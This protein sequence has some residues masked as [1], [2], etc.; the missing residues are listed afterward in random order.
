V[1]NARSTA[2]ASAGAATTRRTAEG[3]SIP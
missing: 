1:P 3:S 2:R